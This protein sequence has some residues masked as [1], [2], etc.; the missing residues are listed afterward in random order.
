QDILCRLKIILL[1]FCALF[2]MLLF[3]IISI[4]RY[5]KII[6][7]NFYDKYVTFQRMSLLLIGIWIYA[8]VIVVPIYSDLSYSRSC[9]AVQ[10]MRQGYGVIMTPHI[11]VTFI[12][13][14]IMYIRLYCHIRKSMVKVNPVNDEAVS[15][16]TRSHQRTHHKQEYEVTKT[17]AILVISFWLSWFQL[18]LVSYIIRYVNIAYEFIFLNFSFLIVC[19]VA[20]MKSWIF[21]LRHKV[22]RKMMKRVLKPICKT[23]EDLENLGFTSHDGF[24][25]IGLSNYVNPVNPPPN[26]QQSH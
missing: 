15:T 3:T 17:L 18:V 5:I 14:T 7:R 2:N 10:A 13:S 9:H 20:G 8:A 24:Q 11:L 16:I 6:Y 21:A 26:Q 23:N 25:T 12:T 1:L 19:F 22:F 4:E